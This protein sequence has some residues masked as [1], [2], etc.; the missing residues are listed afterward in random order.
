MFSRLPD[1]RK[2]SLRHRRG[3]GDIGGGLPSAMP[4]GN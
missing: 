2:L 3:M 4:E 1:K